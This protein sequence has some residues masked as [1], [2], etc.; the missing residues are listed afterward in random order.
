MILAPLARKLDA[1]RLAQVE[2]LLEVHTPAVERI[3]RALEDRTVDD[4]PRAIEAD[5]RSV[6]EAFRETV[7][8]AFDRRFH[9]ERVELMDRDG[10]PR[11][12]QQTE[13]V[14]LDF[15]NKVFG[16]YGTW[17]SLVLDAVEGQER[18]R[19]YEL[20]GGTGGFALYL[21]ARDK[22]PGSAG[23]RVIGSDLS[24]P[25]VA[26]ANQVARRRELEVRFE[27]RDACRLA[28]VSEPVD[29]FVC[30]QSVHHLTPGQVV[31]MLGQAMR[32]AHQGVLVFDLVRSAM[33]AAMGVV[34]DLLTAPFPPFM[35]DGVLSFRRSYLP[36]ELELLARLA[37]ATHWSSR[38][39]SPA[40]VVLRA[41]RKTAIGDQV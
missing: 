39:V 28:A 21:A 31:A 14:A 10:V 34:A 22:G 25:S 15:Q 6:L 32:V 3:R 27:V 12:V 33:L 41:Q 11:W 1:Q 13:V 40:Y 4:I 18:P 17:R 24:E 35:Y 2:P 38:F 19:I 20:A 8:S 7:P 26:R 5:V 37:G 29:L 30:M 9:T 36:G 16:N 23:L